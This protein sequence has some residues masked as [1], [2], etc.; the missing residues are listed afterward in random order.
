[1]LPKPSANQLVAIRRWFW[2]TTI[3]G[4]FSGWDSSQMADDTASIRSFAAGK[5]DA[6]EVSAS[7][8]NSHLWASK[9]FR[10]NSAVSKMLAIMLG[11][12]RPVDLLTGQRIDVDKSL[13]WSNDKEFRHFFPQSFLARKRVAAKDSNV[14]G[15]IVLLTSASNIFISASAPSEYLKRLLDD[16]G[17]SELFR[18]LET[19]L[20]PGGALDA[21]LDDNYEAF[22]ERR[23]GHLHTFAKSLAGVEHA[24]FDFDTSPDEIDDSEFDPTQ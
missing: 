4:Y 1:V 6:L 16:C 15:N 8:P 21:A 22:M 18:R 14:V 3:S 19:N 12:T 20:I 2:L 17:R 7:L 13:A 9:P 5:A 24:R 11:H 10:T 23:S